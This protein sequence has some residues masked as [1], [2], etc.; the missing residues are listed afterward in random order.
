ML[1]L[2]V[3]MFGMARMASEPF[4]FFFFFKQNNKNF[5]DFIYL[6]F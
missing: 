1:V 5:L 4:L 3:H 2:T 6:N